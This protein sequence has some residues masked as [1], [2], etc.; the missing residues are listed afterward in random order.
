MKMIY[1]KIAARRLS[2]S[3]RSYENNKG[4]LSHEDVLMTKSDSR[5]ERKQWVYAMIVVMTLVLRIG[6]MPRVSEAS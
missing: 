6:L 2:L 5:L 4:G 1:S 3:D